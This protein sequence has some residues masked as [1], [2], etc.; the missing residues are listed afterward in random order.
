MKAKVIMEIECGNEEA[1]NHAHKVLW[2]T[3]TSKKLMLQDWKIRTVPS[4]E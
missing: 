1:V 4:K 3:I 2:D